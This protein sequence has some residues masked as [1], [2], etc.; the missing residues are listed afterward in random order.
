MSSFLK[1]KT[2]ICDLTMSFLGKGNKVCNLHII[3]LGYMLGEDNLV[4][5]L[6]SSGVSF[7]SS[8]DLRQNLG[9]SDTVWFLVGGLADKYVHIEDKALPIETN[10]HFAYDSEDLYFRLFMDIK[11]MCES[12][13]RSLICSTLAYV[14]SSQATEEPDDDF[15]YDDLRWFYSADYSRE[16]KRYYLSE[17]VA[18]HTVILRCRTLRG[19]YELLSASTSVSCMRLPMKEIYESAGRYRMKERTLLY[20][21]KKICQD[22]EK[23]TRFE[24]LLNSEC[25]NTPVIQD[26]SEVYDFSSADFINFI[27]LWVSFVKCSRNGDL[28]TQGLGYFLTDEQLE[29]A[30]VLLNSIFRLED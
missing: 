13:V 25:F 29:F 3:Q 1:D 20:A 12:D 27:N 9:A 18:N 8:I 19:D 10:L 4:S 7:L 11:L 24:F 28:A 21:Y 30:K 2:K 6:I 22:K 16:M 15:T 23:I 14:N 5:K 17:D 26:I